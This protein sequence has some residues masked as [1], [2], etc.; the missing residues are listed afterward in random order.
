MFHKRTRSAR[1]AVTAITAVAALALT[2]CSASGGDAGKADPNEKVTLNFTWWGNDDRA[3]RYND[4]IALFEEENPNISIN[5]TFTDYPSYWEK[6]T[7]EGAGG[8]LP[9]VMQFDYSY[10]REYGE[11]GLLLDLT[12]TDIDTSGIEKSV[13]QTGQLDGQTFAL[14]TGT[15]SWA[16]FQNVDLL[17]SIGAEEYA[18]GTDWADYDSFI[19]DVTAKG[20]GTVYGGTDYTQR[21]QMFELWLRQ[22]GKDLFTEDGEIN[23]TEKELTK[24]W[25]SGADIRDGAGIPQQRLEELNPMS[26]LGAGEAATETS[27]DN[28]LAGYLGDSGATNISMVAPPTS[29]DSEKDLYLKP[30]LQMAASASTKHP[31]AA[32]TFIDFMINNEEVGAIFGASRGIPASES[33]REGAGLEGADAQVSDYEDTIAD[34]IGDAP[35]V[36][37]IGYGAIEQDFWDLGKSIGLGAVTV[38][39]AVKQFFDETSITLGN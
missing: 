19:A 2:G 16:L 14:A 20:N 9:D 18:G 27:W 39:D 5:G 22:Q 24:F 33:Q 4:A 29:D 23:F 28:F 12:D 26:G 6:R 17:T 35:P 36:P 30:A 8:G 37:V 21:I 11:R 7:T 31:E 32:A 15:N 34:R 1:L 13:L 10:L 3:T 38:E 25:E